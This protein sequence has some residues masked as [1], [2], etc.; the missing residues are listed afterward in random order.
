MQKSIRKWRIFKKKYLFQKTLFWKK[1]HY[2]FLSRILKV[3]WFWNNFS[4]TSFGICTCISGKQQITDPFLLSSNFQ[5]EAQSVKQRSTA[6]FSPVRLQLV[7]GKVKV[8]GLTCFKV[9]MARKID[10]IIKQSV[11]CTL[12]FFK[13]K[14]SSESCYIPTNMNSTQRCFSGSSFWM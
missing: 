2:N 11:S 13:A 7:T 4:P 9:R 12:T 5:A 1:K 14:L 3:P 8:V 6:S 10:R